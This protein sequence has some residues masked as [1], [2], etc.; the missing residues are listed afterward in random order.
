M[1]IKIPGKFHA[2]ADIVAVQKTD[3]NFKIKNISFLF[4]SQ[5]FVLT[6][7]CK[8]FRTTVDIM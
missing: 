8:T 5:Y 1:Y 4:L 2:A 6:S 3:P 7:T